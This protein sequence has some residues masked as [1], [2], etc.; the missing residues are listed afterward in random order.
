[1]PHFRIAVPGIAL[2]ALLVTPAAPAQELDRNLPFQIDAAAIELDQKTGSAVYRGKVVLVQGSMRIEADRVEVQ[3]DKRRLANVVATGKPVRLRALL[4]NKDDELLANAERIVYRAS[5]RTVELSGNAW[6][7][8]G[9]D[10]FRAQ[11]MTY[12]LDNKRLSA[13]GSGAEDGRVKA[14]FHP[15]PKDESR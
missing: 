4:E 3:M 14:I 2:C 9:A 6:V 8:Q 13:D 11:H 1:M 15:K 7:R 10:E 12:G 5:A